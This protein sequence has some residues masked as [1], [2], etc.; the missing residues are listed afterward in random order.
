MT[1][2]E[3]KY[4]FVKIGDGDHSYLSVRELSNK[5]TKILHETENFYLVRKPNQRYGNN[6]YGYDHSAPTKYIILRKNNDGTVSIVLS[7]EPGPYWKKCVDQLIPYMD[8][9]EEN[10]LPFR[11]NIST[12]TLVDILE[13]YKT[14]IEIGKTVLQ[15][16]EVDDSYK[17]AATRLLILANMNLDRIN[18]ELKRRSDGV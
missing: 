7:E 18:M 16:A 12:K 10:I 17:A 6:Y 1:K 8:K 13:S 14:I 15:G 4:K 3:F 2:Q 5:H 9:L 11:Q